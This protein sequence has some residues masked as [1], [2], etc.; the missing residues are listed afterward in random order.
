M[1]VVYTPA[2]LRHDPQ[3]EIEQSGMHSP[4]EHI[5]RAEAIREVLQADPGFT[6]ESPSAFGVAP[7]HA[8]HQ[9]GL[10]TFIASAW[11]E[12]QVVNPGTRDVVPD[13]FYR[14][15][16]RR[17][18][19]PAVVPKSINGRLGWFC[20]ETTTPLTE[21]TYVAARGAVDTALSAT[22]LVLGGDRAAYALCRP[23]GHHATSSNYGGYCFFNNAAIA[24]HHAASTTGTRVTVLDV[25]YHHGNGTQEIFYERDDVQYVSLHANPDRAYPYTI[26]YA[27]ETGAGRGSGSTLNLPLAERVDDDGYLAGLERAVEAVDRFGPS[28]LIVSLGLDTFVTDP[29]CDLAVTAEGFARS[30]ALVGSLGVPTVVV[31]EGGYD[32]SALGDNVRRWLSGLAGPGPCGNAGA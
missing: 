11:A 23:P 6:F 15:S 30:G 26:G 25:D 13:V 24:A 18:M 8:V 3:T 27:D 2:H 14:P 31:Q 19:T 29:I 5:G 4:W 17:G 28:L 12:Y 22:Q 16:I 9:R 7:I 20:F 32:V 21:G 1:K 10:E